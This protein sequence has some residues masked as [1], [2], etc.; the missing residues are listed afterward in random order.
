MKAAFAM[1]LPF[2]VP[3]DKYQKFLTRVIK[4]DEMFSKF[5]ILCKLLPHHRIV[6]SLALFKRNKRTTRLFNIVV[7]A[8]MLPESIRITIFVTKSWILING[9]R[10]F[11]TNIAISDN[12]R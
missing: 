5:I 4:R 9:N 1:T 6:M 8:S 2:S 11:R 3:R 10:M 7:A 12:Y